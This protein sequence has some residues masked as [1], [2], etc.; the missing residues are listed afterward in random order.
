MKFCQTFHEVFTKCLTNKGYVLLIVQGRK[1]FK[2]YNA[3]QTE[4]SNQEILVVIRFIED[5]GLNLEWYKY[6]TSTGRRMPSGSEF[7]RV[8]E[9]NLPQQMHMSKLKGQYFGQH[10]GSSYALDDYIILAKK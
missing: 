1:L 4:D 2:A 6:A 3:R 5:L 10:Y 9:E 7:A 8:A